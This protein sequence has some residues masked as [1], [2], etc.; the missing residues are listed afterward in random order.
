MMNKFHFVKGMIKYFG[1]RKISILSFISSSNII[2]PTVSVRRFAKIKNAELGAYSYVGNNTDIEDAIIGKYCSIS[3]HC[4]IG[5]S[6][7]TLNHI[8]TSPIFTEKNNGCREAWVD[9]DVI[10]STKR[11]VV[12]G[13]DV[14]IGSHALIG[15]GVVIGD[16]AVVG[17]GAVVVKDVPPYAIVGGVPAKLIRYRFSNEIIDRLLKARWW[18]LPVDVLRA[19]IHLFQSP[20]VDYNLCDK[21]IES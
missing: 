15:D 9:K 2:Q 5:L 8:S 7:H 18:D 14:W 3:D 19:K 10:N 20:N 6:G 11:R 17:A 21:L 1:N 16:G 13:N 12:I 4:R